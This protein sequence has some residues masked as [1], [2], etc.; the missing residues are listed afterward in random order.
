MKKISKIIRPAL[1]TV[2]ILL[3]PFF[4]NLFVDGWNWRWTAFIFFG[5]ILFGAGLAYEFWGKYA[6]K[7]VIG[8]FFFGELIAA[9]II[10]L[11]RFLNP[12]D[13]V[14]GVVII[15]F[16]IFGIFF[17]ILGYFIQRFLEKRR[18]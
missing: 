3:I 14:A 7:G 4:G 10:A 5:V 6:K 15:T 2:G 16:L 11:L 1:I 9:G 12:N 18:G 8:G 17:A 13:D